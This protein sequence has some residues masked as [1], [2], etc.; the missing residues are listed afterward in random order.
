MSSPLPERISMALKD[1]FKSNPEDHARILFFLADSQANGV[2]EPYIR[3]LES[4]INMPAVFKKVAERMAEDTKTAERD[5]QFRQFMYNV[6][7][8]FMKD[9]LSV[10]PDGGQRWELAVPNYSAV[11]YNFMRYVAAL[12]PE[13]FQ[14]LQQAVQSIGGA[15]IVA[16]YANRALS[17]ARSARPVVRVALVVVVLAWDVIKNISRWWKGEISGARCVKNIIDCGVSVA[18]GI[19]GGMGGEAIGAMIGSLAGPVGTVV[20]GIAGAVVG[21]ATASFTAQSLCDRLTQWVFGLPKSEALDKAYSFLGVSAN[22]SNSD[23]NSRY[24]QLAL[25]YHPDKGGDKEQWVQLQYSMAV[26]REAR[27]EP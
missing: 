3:S 8:N 22:A 2:A 23:V 6:W 11:Q 15:G 14:I 26:I 19:A 21:S 20:G 4:V 12:P 5:P 24:R 13:S 17:K 27:G 16:R 10:H 18:A 1:T 9:N 25:Q 7:N